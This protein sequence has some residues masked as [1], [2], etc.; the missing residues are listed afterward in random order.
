MEKAP[1][2]GW[3]QPQGLRLPS[4]HTCCLLSS[5]TGVALFPHAQQGFHTWQGVCREVW[6]K[7][8]AS[9]ALLLVG[10]PLLFSAMSYHLRCIQQKCHACGCLEPTRRSGLRQ[11]QSQVNWLNC[12]KKSLILTG[13]DSLIFSFFRLNGLGQSYTVYFTILKRAPYL[14]LVIWIWQ[15]FIINYNIINFKTS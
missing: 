8:R 4:L 5:V 14:T 15:N 2:P 11:L 13:K 1:A 10:A 12:C 7:W 3:W 9:C 6:A